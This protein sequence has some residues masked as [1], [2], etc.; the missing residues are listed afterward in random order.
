MNACIIWEH[1][2]TVPRIFP[3]YL[4]PSSSLL[5]KENKENYE[6]SVL[7]KSD[8]YFTLKPCDFPQLNQCEMEGE[9]KAGYWGEISSSWQSHITN[10]DQCL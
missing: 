10:K 1:I 2:V 8:Y 9:K 6:W 7:K 5:P 4:P 3:T